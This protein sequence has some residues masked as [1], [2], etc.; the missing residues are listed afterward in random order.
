MMTL[1]FRRWLPLCLLLLVGLPAVSAQTI[2]KIEIRHVGP[3]AASDDLIKANIKVKVGDTFNARSVEDDVRTLY[4][5][6]LFWNIQFFVEPTLEGVNLVYR[7][8]GNLTL[9]DIGFEGN[10]KYKTPKLF[11]KVTSKVGERLDERKLFADAQEIQKMYQ[12][13]GYQKTKVEYK[14]A[15]VE[16]G[17][18]RGSVIFEITESP[19][20]RIERIEFVGAQAFAQK[21]LR[22]QIKTRRHWMFSWLTG[23]GVLK[24]EQFDDD[25]DKLAAF[26]RNEGYIDFE[27]KDIQFDSPDPRHLIIRFLISEGTQYKVGGV[28]FKG[29][30]IFTADE[31]SKGDKSSKGIQMGVGQV[32]TPKGL[33]ADIEAIRDFYGSKGYIDTWVRAIK[34]PNV[35]KG[36]MDLIYEIRDED[37]G[38]S[39]IEKIEIKG[40]TKTKDKVIRRELAV[41]PGEVFDM[42]RVKRS[43]GRL[44]Q[45][46]FFDKIET[47]VDPTDIP[48][49]KNLVVDVQEASTGNI[50]LG[51]GF[52]SVDNLVGFVGFREGNFDLFN[53]PYFRGGGPLSAIKTGPCARCSMQISSQLTRSFTKGGTEARPASVVGR[54]RWCPTMNSASTGAR[55]VPLVCLPVRCTYQ[56]QPRCTGGLVGGRSIRS[57]MPNEIPPSSSFDHD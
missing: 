9:A 36:T 25:K 32:F 40:N 34:N 28:Q 53:P 7:V 26:Y 18:G 22:K 12:K 37:K 49:R 56:N 4:A 2:Q 45:M 3:H 27:L 54:S 42:V 30:S 24:D 50:E 19:K 8:Q 44:E 43:K 51:A 23:S 16:E 29:N 35:E 52:S 5:T 21:K 20:V 6:G 33:D 11:K 38:K 57:R 47:E 31:I 17:T 10:K 46:Q 48:N 1:L 13:A 39:F 41:A 15:N 55:G 14:L